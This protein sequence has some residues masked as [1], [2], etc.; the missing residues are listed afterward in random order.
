MDEPK[1]LHLNLPINVLATGSSGNCTI[2]DNCIMIDCG[3]SKKLILE[4]IDPADIKLLIVTHLHGDHWNKSTAKWLQEE[5]GVVVFMG[6]LLQTFTFGDYS[7]HT[8]PMKHNVPC[9]GFK[10]E[11]WEYD[12]LF[13]SHL[14]WDLMYATDTSE[15]E[16]LLEDPRVYNCMYYLLESNYD[17]N[18]VEYTLDWIKNTDNHLGFWQCTNFYKIVGGAKSMLM[19]MH[20]SKFRR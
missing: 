12:E 10:I 19:R 15:L 3:V 9:V 16:H 6:N 13:K 18:K 14:Q 2:I 4:H 17:E 20:P 5:Y 8:L 7:I 11:K 1:T